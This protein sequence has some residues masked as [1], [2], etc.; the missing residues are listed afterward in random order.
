V[1]TWH[2]LAGD[3]GFRDD[4]IALRLTALSE[5]DVRNS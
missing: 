4:T 1:Q 3:V 2:V 5:V